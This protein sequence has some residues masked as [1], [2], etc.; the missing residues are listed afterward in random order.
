MDSVSGGGRSL[1][2]LRLL[3]GPL[4]RPYTRL[5]QL[6]AMLDGPYITYHIIINVVTVDAI[7]YPLAEVP[8]CRDRLLACCDP[9]N[10]PWFALPM[11]LSP[12][13]WLVG[14]TLAYAHAAYMWARESPAQHANLLLCQIVWFF[15]EM[16]TFTHTVEWESLVFYEGDERARTRLFGAGHGHPCP[17]RP[18]FSTWI[19]IWQ[20]FL[21]N[22]L[23]Q[24]L[25]YA[26]VVYVRRQR[27]RATDRKKRDAEDADSVAFQA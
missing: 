14:H 23:G 1:A 8:F 9:L 27:E 20:D 6:T 25:G 2:R 10:A 19:P 22:C 13:G 7:N 4:E 17:G 21:Y 16:L 5:R 11:R 24:L 26:A 18:Y 12:C 3:A 15:F